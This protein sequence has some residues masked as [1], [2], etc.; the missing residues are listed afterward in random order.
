MADG[1]SGRLVAGDHQECEEVLELEVCERLAIW[2]GG[3]Q[4]GEYVVVRVR[5]SF[6]GYLLGV[7]V[8]LQGG[9]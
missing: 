3:E 7:S 6:Q 8:D 5:P 9:R 2:L 4:R 1:V